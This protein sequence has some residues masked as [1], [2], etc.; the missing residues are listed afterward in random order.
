M[1]VDVFGFAEHQEKA[2]YGIGCNLTLAK[3]SDKS[4]LNIANG[5]NKAKIEINFINECVPHYTPSITQQVI[6]SKEISSK[7]PTRLQYGERSIFKKEVKTGN[8]FSF[9]LVTQEGINVRKWIIVGFQ[10]RDRQDSQNLNNDTFYRLPVTSSNSVIGTEKYPDSPILINYDDDFYSQGY[11]RNEEAFR[12][13]AKHDILNSF[14]ADHDFRST[15]VNDAGDD[16]DSVG[17]KLYAF[18]DDIGEIELAHANKVAFKFSE[19]LL[20]CIV[21]L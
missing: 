3:N 6:L 4:V 5:I 2:T 9:K 10:Q 14:I 11:V 19:I 13:L 18:V 17:Y 21:F 20:G 1:L 7:I 15:N 8:F 12:A 16:D